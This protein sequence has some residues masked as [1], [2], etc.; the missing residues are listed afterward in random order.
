[1]EEFENELAQATE[2]NDAVSAALRQGSCGEGI[3]DELLLA[4]LAQLAVSPKKKASAETTPIASPQATQSA[5]SAVTPQSSVSAVL[6]LLPEPIP[7]D[8]PLVQ[9]KSQAQVASGALII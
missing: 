4:E 1:M 7:A 2:T 6:A 5:P 9:K 3:E 8:A